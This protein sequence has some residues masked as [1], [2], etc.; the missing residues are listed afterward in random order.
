MRHCAVVSKTERVVASQVCNVVSSTNGYDYDTAVSLFSYC[1]S[2][3]GERAVVTV[4]GASRT[5]WW[6]HVDPV[7]SWRAPSGVKWQSPCSGSQRPKQPPW[8]W[9]IL[10]FR[11]ST[12]SS[13]GTLPIYIYSKTIIIGEAAAWS[14][15]AWIR[16]CLDSSTASTTATFIVH[17]NLD[18]CNSLY[19]KLPISSL[20]RLQPIPNSLARTVVAASRSCHI[21]SYALSTDS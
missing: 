3:N 11:T 2:S 20:S 8:S 21:L 9:K 5:W 19:H 1:R 4:K 14:A 12:G 18:Y 16:H 17:S 15:D 7:G 10:S 13:S 6:E